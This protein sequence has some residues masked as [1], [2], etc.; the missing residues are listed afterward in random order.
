MLDQT[1]QD[2]ISE[3]VS[4]AGAVADLTGKS[5][6]IVKFND[7]KQLVFGWASVSTV[8]GEMIVDKQGDMI[9]PD[10][11][12]DAAYDFVLYHRKHGDMHERLGTGRLIE[13]MMFTLEKQQALGIDL[14]M[15]GWW[16]GFKVDDAAV[17]KRIK[18]GDLPEFS[19]G[20][21]ATR[22]EA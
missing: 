19:I 22:V 9:A 3:A 17:W 5:C 2:I 6:K 4:K 14:G 16:V 12:E 21:K 15:E 20:G 18:A 11:L 7:D 10:T 13:S 8:G 1:T